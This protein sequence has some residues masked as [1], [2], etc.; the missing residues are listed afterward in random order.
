[1][2]TNRGSQIV[3][4]AAVAALCSGAAASGCGGGDDE[5]A[6]STPTKTTTNTTSEGRFVPSNFGAPATGANKWLPLEPGTQTVRLG[7]VSRGSRRLTHRVVTTVTDVSK[8]I[9]GVR[10][11]A[12]LDQDIDA[13]QTA[14]QALDFLAEDE[15]GNVWYVGSYTEAYE[16][17]QFVNVADAWLAGVKGGSAGILMQADPRTG[18]PPY[19]QAK[20]PGDEVNV[21]EVAKTG[22]SNCVPFKCYKNVLVVEEGGEYKYFAPGVGH[23]RTEPREE[24]GE[25][26]VEE[27]INFTQLSPRA[28]AELS[29]ET[30]KLDRHAREA[31]KDVFG[32]SPP[33]KRTL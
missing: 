23:I 9:D 24:G 19:V 29:A 25:Q 15:Q 30:L 22:Q 17:G 4:A 18:T 1:M 32:S 14:E 3:A 12:V 28:L 31:K 2:L 7:R 26:E 11:V 27:L 20:I 10:T 13:G 33:A 21:A 5:K 16:G 8:E 6:A